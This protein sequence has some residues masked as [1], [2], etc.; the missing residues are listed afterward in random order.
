MGYTAAECIK[1]QFCCRTS[2]F[3]WAGARKLENS[4]THG[5]AWKKRCDMMR[6]LSTFRYQKRRIKIT[7]WRTRQQRFFGFK[8]ERGFCIWRFF[9]ADQ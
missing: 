9:N 8:K 1:H 5:L 4:L 7:P 2:A 6:W 3:D